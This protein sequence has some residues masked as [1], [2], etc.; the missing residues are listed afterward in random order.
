MS[1]DYANIVKVEELKN[2]VIVDQIDPNKV[3]VS[4]NGSPTRVSATTWLY[5]SGAPWTVTIDI[6]VGG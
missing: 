1:A 3:T 6:E 5:S 4:I 2:A